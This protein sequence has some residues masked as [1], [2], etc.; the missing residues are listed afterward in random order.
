M[1]RKDKK[2]AA[3]PEGA[4]PQVDKWADL[5]RRSWNYPEGSSRRQKR[6]WRQA[7]HD[8]RKA[9]LDH[10][11]EQ[12]QSEDP[13]GGLGFAVLVALVVVIGLI[14]AAVRGFGGQDSPVVQP[15]TAAPR[16]ST[17]A[18]PSPSP[19]S[20]D[21]LPVVPPASADAVAE[22]WVRAW[23]AYAPASGDSQDARMERARPY[24]TPELAESLGNVDDPIARV[25][26]NEGTN[27]E[28]T[29]VAV[30]LAGEPAPIDTDVRVTRFVD[31]T[32]TYAAGPLAGQVVA[33]RQVVTLIVVDN[34]WRVGD[35][36]SQEL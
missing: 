25:W 4:G 1:T 8:A 14:V 28:V 21:S 27:V 6:A 9:F 36:I 30:S 3:Q 10:Q 26:E 5:F 2:K 18:S 35:V 29:D 19:T 7:D 22:A 12:R 34:T 32:M 16:A 15:T 23:L 33:V 11:R 17:A 13:S 24:M 31:A 20:D